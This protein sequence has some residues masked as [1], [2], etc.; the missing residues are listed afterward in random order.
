MADKT[1]TNKDE[2]I[3]INQRSKTQQIIEVA[4]LKAVLKTPEGFR[5]I[6]RIMDR[7]KVLNNCFTGNSSTYFNEGR[8]AVALDV[9]RD[10][11]LIGPE[12]SPTIIQELFT[13][14]DFL[15]KQKQLEENEDG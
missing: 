8:K 7:S 13:S 14:N 2:A 9:L 15:P 3:E 6:Q 10:I 11:I 4:D 1:A 12:I 5:F